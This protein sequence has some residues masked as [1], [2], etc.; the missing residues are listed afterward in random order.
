VLSP[1]MT[2]ISGAIFVRTGSYS[3]ALIILIVLALIGATLALLGRA[4]THRA[5]FAG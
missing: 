4:G 1:F 3:L 5:A 2:P